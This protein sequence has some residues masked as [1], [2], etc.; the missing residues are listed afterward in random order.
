MTRIAEHNLI[1]PTLAA[2]SMNGGWISTSDL[3]GHLDATFGPNGKDDDII[4]NRFDT[5]FSQKVRNMI[6]HRKSKASFI[7]R[8]FAKY[9]Q[10]PAANNKVI[11]GLAITAKGKALLAA[12]PAI[13]A[14]ALDPRPS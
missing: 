9:A 8:G 5:F 10:K 14:I 4:E 6:C 1:I 7:A 2:I 12:D 11:G 13:Q 3:I